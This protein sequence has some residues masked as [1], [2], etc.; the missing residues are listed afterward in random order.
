MKLS[1]VSLTVLLAALFIVDCSR[2]E[3]T[4]QPPAKQK[5]TQDKPT[6]EKALEN[7]AKYLNGQ[8]CDSCYGY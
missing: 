2:V 1:S 6:L 5:Q 8:I 4:A 3:T 7:P